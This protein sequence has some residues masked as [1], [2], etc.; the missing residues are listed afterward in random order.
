MTRDE[1]LELIAQLRQ[2]A[3]AGRA[4]VA[5]GR[6]CLE[7]DPDLVRGGTRPLVTKKDAADLM[8][9]TYTP[10]PEEE[11]AFT[12]TQEQA[13]AEFVVEFT[14]KKLVPLQNR[15][16]KLEAEL[17]KLKGYQRCGIAQ[18]VGLISIAVG[19]L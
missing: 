6:G 14:N 3:G 8:Y 16:A 10:P 2:P 11:A 12:D 5:R 17:K 18:Y 1:R 7:A 9:K 19:R 13:I 15:I 4:G